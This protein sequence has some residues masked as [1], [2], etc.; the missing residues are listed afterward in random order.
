[1]INYSAANATASSI[2]KKA[3]H[4]PAINSHSQLRPV[5]R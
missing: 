1:M 5:R 3:H 2:M 4:A